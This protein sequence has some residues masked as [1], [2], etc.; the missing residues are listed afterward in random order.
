LSLVQRLRDEAEVIY[1][2]FDRTR[3]LS[4]AG[5]GCV[6]AACNTVVVEGNYLLHDAP[7]WRDLR[8][9]WDMSIALDV[10]IAVLRQ[11][12]IDR[13]LAHG[14]PLEEAR[15]RAEGND[16]ANAALIARH[17]LPADMTIKNM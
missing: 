14:L 16:L 9:H 5:A 4:I 6:D 10:D 11:R 1:P 7:V 17:R 2:I 13:W 8:P 3:D 12:L 15:Q